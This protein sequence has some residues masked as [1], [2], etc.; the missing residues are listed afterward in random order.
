MSDTYITR[1]DIFEKL[2][3]S[4]HT[5]QRWIKSGKFPQPIKFGERLVRWK[6]STVDA[7]VKQNESGV[8]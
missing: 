5:L 3:I 4:S 7:W 8:A 1:K 6:L 2:G